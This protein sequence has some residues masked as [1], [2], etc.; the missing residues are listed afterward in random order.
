MT[1]E[2]RTMVEQYDFATVFKLLDEMESC[3]D[4]VR[5]LNDSLD[6]NPVK[7]KLAA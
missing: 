7:T 4:K 1:H 2:E 5:L 6:Q 3:V